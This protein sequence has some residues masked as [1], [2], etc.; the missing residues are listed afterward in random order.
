MRM[1][2][3]KGDLV[4]EP[5]GGSGS[6]VI[7][8]AKEGRRCYAMELSPAFCD[9]IRRRWTKYARSAGIEPGAGGLE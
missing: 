5:F 3:A 2:T 1:H 4:L 9:V 8:A 6:Q 7:A